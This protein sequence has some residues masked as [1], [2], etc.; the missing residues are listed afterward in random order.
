[1]HTSFIVSA[2][3]STA[4]PAPRQLSLHAVIAAARARARRPRLIVALVA[5]LV[6]AAALSLAIRDLTH[7]TPKLSAAR[8]FAAQ[9]PYIGVACRVPNE[10]ACGRVGLAVWLLRAVDHLAAT[11]GARTVSIPRASWGGKV[12]TYI[13]YVRFPREALHLPAHWTGN[14]PRVLTV[15]LRAEI[16]GA[17]SEKIV[18]LPLHAGWG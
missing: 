2:N 5:T 9:P 14:P 18:R 15:H 11:I 10:T 13:A 6:A 16:G 3:S 7:A 12:I 17:T 4:P 1:M 8:V